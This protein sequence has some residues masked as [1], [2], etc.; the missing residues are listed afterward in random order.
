[1][2]DYL[3]N[4]YFRDIILKLIKQYSAN[5]IVIQVSSDIKVK[6]ADK[7]R[8]EKNN[9]NTINQN[10]IYEFVLISHLEN[11]L[12]NKSG[13]IFMFHYFTLFKLIKNNITKINTKDKQ[14]VIVKKQL[15]PYVIKK[16][17]TDVELDGFY[18]IVK[19]LK[20]STDDQKSVETMVILLIIQYRLA[21]YNLNHLGLHGI[22]FSRY[23]PLLF[24]FLLL[25][26]TNSNRKLH[27]V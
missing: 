13:K 26:N 2:E 22:H 3:F 1:M 4:K 20:L 25:R 24:D 21:L 27:Y 19:K 23:F 12:K 11:I 6:S 5:Y 8:L 18:N 17:T 14:K 9:L 10:E 7:I 16:W 15:E